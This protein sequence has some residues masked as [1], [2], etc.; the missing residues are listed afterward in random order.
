[1]HPPIAA[2]DHISRFTG[3][4]YNPRE[5]MPLPVLADLCASLGCPLAPEQITQAEAFLDALYA[6]NEVRNLTRVPREEAEV[7]H[8]CD[9]VLALDLIPHGSHVLDI[10]TG[11]GL[12]AW[13]LACVRPDLTVTALDGSERMFAPMR[14]VPLPNLHPV[15]GRAEDMTQVEAYD[16]VIGRALAP[17][18]V[19]LEISAQPLKLGGLAIPFRSGADWEEAEQL[20]IGQLGLELEEMILRE[21]PRETGQRLFPIYRKVRPTDSQFPRT[22][23]RMKAKPLGGT[24]RD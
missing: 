1:M 3:T 21:L 16:V 22:W 18:P 11:P 8:L 2:L 7:K 9:S 12:P 15:Q 17:L 5:T 10:G 20:N 13:P 4:V 23:A 24:P 19:Q 6:E 14:A